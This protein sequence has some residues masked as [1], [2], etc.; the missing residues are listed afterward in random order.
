MLTAKRKIVIELD[1]KEY[2]LLEN[3]Q[4]GGKTWQ[5]RREIL[6]IGIYQKIGLDLETD[7]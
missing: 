2:E 1:E 3:A 4:G 5:S 6:L 7:T